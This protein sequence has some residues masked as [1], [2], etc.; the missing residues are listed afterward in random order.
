MSRS[1]VKI[2]LL[3]LR[4]CRS[5]YMLFDSEQIAKEY[6]DEINRT[7]EVLEYCLFPNEAFLVMRINS[8]R[9]ILNVIW[10]NIGEN[11]HR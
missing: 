7:Q 1:R 5:Q 9:Y 6:I 2:P 4:E 8:K 11:K 3:E 10:G